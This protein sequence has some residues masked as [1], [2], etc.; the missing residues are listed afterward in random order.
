MT[1]LL[2]CLRGSLLQGK[3]HRRTAVTLGIW[4]WPSDERDDICPV[5]MH[6]R[7]PS[8]RYEF[9]LQAAAVPQK[10]APHYICRMGPPGEVKVGLQLAVAAPIDG[11]AAE[12]ATDAPVRPERSTSNLS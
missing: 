3:Q 1:T 12:E 7:Q 4:P 10:S 8:H 2:H 5:V 11:P 6:R 9:I